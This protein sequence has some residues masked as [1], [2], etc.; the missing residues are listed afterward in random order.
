M[1]Y[2]KDHDIINI[3]R[4]TTF[5][6]VYIKIK[7]FSKYKYLEQVLTIEDNKLINFFAAKNNKKKPTKTSHHCI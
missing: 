3:L 7:C 6:S 5:N 4:T 2:L 1:L